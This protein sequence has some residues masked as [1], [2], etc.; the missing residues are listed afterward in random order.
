M[1]KTAAEQLAG[2]PGV[3][4]AREAAHWALTHGLPRVLIGRLARKGDL[5]AKLIMASSQDGD[6]LWDLIEQV[7]AEGPVVKSGIAY[8]TPDHATVRE[9]L[10][11]DA[12]R[13]GI[14]VR[15][16]TMGHPGRHRPLRRPGLLPERPP[17]SDGTDHHV[18]P[19]QGAQ[20]CQE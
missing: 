8:L 7:R 3:H 1:N 18:E 14:P 5:Q 17:H 15:V 20:V 16:G 19:P 9:V 2:L 4:T 12:F 10:T 11:S 6:E 13:T